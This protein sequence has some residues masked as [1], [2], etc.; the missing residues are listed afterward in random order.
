MGGV[1]SPNMGL[2]EITLD[3][4][5]Q[6]EK[7]DAHQGNDLPQQAPATL[8]LRPSV[9]H[10][11]LLDINLSPRTTTMAIRIKTNSFLSLSPKQRLAHL[12]YPRG[13]I[14]LV[15]DLWETD[16]GPVY[17]GEASGLYQDE[18]LTSVFIKSL[19]NSAST[20]QRQQFAIEMT[21]ASG[22][23][24][25]NIITL[26]GVC[27]REVPHYMIFEYLEY[28]S[29]KEFLQTVGDAWFD[30]DQF[31]GD[32]ESENFENSSEVPSQSVFGVEDLTA[33]A[34]Q[35]ANGMD[36]LAKKAFVLKDLAARNCQVNNI[37]ESWGIIF[38]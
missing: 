3:T 21:W 20:K 17:A 36:Y 32:A 14:C 11:A 4:I 29:L 16:I 26:L 34:C 1:S 5:A 38:Y 27:T 31:L 25:P 30:F 12:E 23:S 13:N 6:G 19:R 8:M 22:F 24:H 10:E 28:G 2:K 33:M 35:V 18:S 37:L 9:V 15:R 7:K